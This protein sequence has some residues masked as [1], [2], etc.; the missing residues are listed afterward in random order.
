[1]PT[2]AAKIG[3][4]LLS[5]HVCANVYYG[6]KCNID[7]IDYIYAKVNVQNCWCFSLV[8]CGNSKWVSMGVGNLDMTLLLKFA[9]F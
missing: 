3:T 6:G 9:R 7:G 5:L 8:Y 4:I 2:E 1:M